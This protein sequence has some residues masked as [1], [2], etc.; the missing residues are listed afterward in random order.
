M[1][2]GWG[3]TRASESLSVDLKLENGFGLKVSGGILTVAGGLQMTSP[4]GGSTSS[5]LDAF[6]QTQAQAICAVKLGFMAYDVTFAI[7]RDCTSRQPTCRDVCESTENSPENQYGELTCV[8]AMHVYLD[9]AEASAP[10]PFSTALGKRGLKTLNYGVGDAD[11]TSC[12]IDGCGPNFCCCAPTS[13]S[14]R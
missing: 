12:D 4:I 8:T 1:F 10:G 5:L 7:P 3:N 14:G 2:I 9:T 11:D 6:V 13:Q